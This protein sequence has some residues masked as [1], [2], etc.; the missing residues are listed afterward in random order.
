L[1]APTQLDYVLLHIY[2]SDVSDSVLGTLKLTETGI[3]TL[4]GN[5]TIELLGMPG[6]GFINPGNVPD[7]WRLVKI[8]LSINY[9]E[10]DTYYFAAQRI[11][12]TDFVDSDISAARFP[13]C[14]KPGT[15]VESFDFEVLNGTVDGT[16]QTSGTAGKGALLVLR[17]GDVQDKVFT[18]WYYFTG[19]AGTET[20]GSL[21]ALSDV[22]EIAVTTNLKIMAFFDDTALPLIPLATLANGANQVFKW[23]GEG[24]LIEMFRWNDG[25]AYASG[26]SFAAGI[27]YLKVYIYEST[28]ANTETDSVGSFKYISGS[29]RPVTSLD[30]T[31]TVRNAAGAAGLDNC[32][33]YGNSGDTDH[34]DLAAVIAAAIGGGYSST[35]NYYFAV[36]SI[37][38][39]S[40]GYSDS[41]ISVIGTVAWHAPV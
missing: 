35:K 22:L 30:G 31:L 19:I 1:I 20:K 41:G 4:D 13:L 40:S 33:L 17:H 25:T 28:A 9:N 11:A 21:I 3:T 34:I 36:Q 7:F 5:N 15:P 10:A 12:K 24:V 16:A 32:T 23:D 26:S 27:D 6:N 38:Q 14:E 18:G 37:A 39:A 29:D 8:A 2:G